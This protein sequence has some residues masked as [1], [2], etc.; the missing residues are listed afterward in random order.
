[1]TA[2]LAPEDTFEA[3]RRAA[4]RRALLMALAGVGLVALVAAAIG[5]MV[6]AF[7]GK[8][9]TY[10]LVTATL[11]ADQPVEPGAEVSYL[12]VAIGTVSGL[13]TAHA[14]GVVTVALHL[15][16]A[17]IARVPGNVTVA[18]APSSV[19][20][21]QAVVLQ[22]PH[23]P[24]GHLH[25]GEVLAP[26]QSGSAS[27]Q[28]GLTSLNNVLTGLHPAEIDTALGALATTLA[29]QGQ[30][31]G[32]AVDA[33][34]RYLDDLIPQLPTL[35]SDTNA[36]TPALTGFTAAVP[37]LLQAA[38]NSAS[39]ARTIATQ[40]ADLA[41][42]LSSGGSVASTSTAI[43]DATQ[44]SLRAFLTNFLPLLVDLQ[45]DPHVLPETLGNLDALSRNLFPALEK[46]PYLVFQADTWFSNPN[47]AILAGSFVLPASTEASDAHDAFA[48]VTDPITYGAADCPRYGAQ[49]G[50]NCPAGGAPT[51]WSA[52]PPSATTSAASS[53]VAPAVETDVAAA[54]LSSSDHTSVAASTPAAETVLGPLLASLVP[55]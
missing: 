21:V 26:A 41:G 28:S 15:D 38:A 9:S 42:L 29:G 22:A 11:P 40:G 54:L 33:L 16:P 13:G 39:V 36:V 55:R 4:R 45:A 25:P 35:Q 1:M 34:T 8:F 31:V 5:G 32:S 51:R 7:A 37:G 12:Q 46:G 18:V 43:I 47:D 14:G 17:K 6:G 10:T 27:L 52:P 49:S 20:G 53:F 2:V 3:R 50:P 44:Q 23:D 24:S 30:S 19:F 48:A